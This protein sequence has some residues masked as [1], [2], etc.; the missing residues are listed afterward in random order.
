[1]L[2]VCKPNCSGRCASLEAGL[3]CY[4]QNCRMGETGL[5]E[6][7]GADMTTLTLEQQQDIARRFRVL[8]PQWNAIRRYRNL[9]M[10]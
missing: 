2:R 5:S 7:G 10:I 1:L 6:R 3:P 8:V 9:R 4:H